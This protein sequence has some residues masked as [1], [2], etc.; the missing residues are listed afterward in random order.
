MFAWGS[1]WL[2]WNHTMKLHCLD[3]I[4]KFRHVTECVDCIENSDWEKAFLRD[5][6]SLV[7]LA[8]M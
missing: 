3:Q 2:R 6:Y 1:G 5:E 4:V 7:V 8:A